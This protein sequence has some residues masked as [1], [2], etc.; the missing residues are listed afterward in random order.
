VS[1]LL[2]PCFTRIESSDLKG[3]MDCQSKMILAK[4]FVASHCKDAFR[5]PSFSS[6]S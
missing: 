6:W 3:S 4:G 5:W 1:L 2:L